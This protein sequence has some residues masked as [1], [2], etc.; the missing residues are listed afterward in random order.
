M[1][2]IFSRPKSKVLYTPSTFHSLCALSHHILGLFPPPSPVFVTSRLL[3]SATVLHLKCGTHTANFQPCLLRPRSDTSRPCRRRL[4]RGRACQQ[5]SMPACCAAVGDFSPTALARLPC[6]P[7]WRQFRRE[8]LAGTRHCCQSC[9]GG[10]TDS[11][12]SPY[13]ARVATCARDESVPSFY[14]PR[15]S[16]L[17]S[18][19]R[20]IRLS[21]R[22]KCSY[23][24]VARARCA[25][26]A[27]TFALLP[28]RTQPASRR[29]APRASNRSRSQSRKV[30]SGRTS[31]STS[32]R[33]PRPGRTGSWCDRPDAFLS[34]SRQKHYA[35][36][37]Q[38]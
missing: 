8:P 29:V 27:G 4:P 3:I 6:P 14:P 23:A 28:G 1:V 20:Q 11:T 26:G 5:S 12:P 30:R 37:R 17:L 34:A 36:P 33:L 16:H 31:R 22:A 13:G 25:G 7:S 15:E 19:T 38:S 24:L 32:L 35:T 9:T 2:E 10:A 18:F 21:R